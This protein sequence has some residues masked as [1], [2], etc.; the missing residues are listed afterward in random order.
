M[1]QK[2]DWMF[3]IVSSGVEICQDQYT[4]TIIRQVAALHLGYIAMCMQF[5][6]VAV[7]LIKKSGQGL[8]FPNHD[9]GEVQEIGDIAWLHP[10]VLHEVKVVGEHSDRI[11]LVFTF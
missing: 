11:A 6:A 4:T 3:L 9:Q 5:F 8:Y 1:K 2:T 7:V 10:N